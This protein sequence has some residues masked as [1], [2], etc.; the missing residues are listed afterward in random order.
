MFDRKSPLG[1]LVDAELRKDG[2]LL[3]LRTM[4]LRADA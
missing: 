1:A 2:V 4:A 3:E